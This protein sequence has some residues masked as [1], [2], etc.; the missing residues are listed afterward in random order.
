MFYLGMQEQHFTFT[1]FDAQAWWVRDVILGKIS[2]PDRP[3][4]EAHTVENIQ[5]ADRLRGLGVQERVKFQ[6]NYIRELL[7]ETDYPP[8]D[9][10]LV[11]HHF[12]QWER[13]K[14]K[15]IIG[16][17]DKAFM[18][19]VDGTLGT[20]PTVRRLAVHFDFQEDLK[21]CESKEPETPS[22]TASS[23]FM[24]SFNTGM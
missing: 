17:R 13:D 16:Y 9:I 6:A 19:A 5:R 21:R 3:A 14:E 10:D 7:E 18:S 24:K 22:E 4:M 1:M 15:S 11:V 2:L 20:L 8:F 23:F 12:D